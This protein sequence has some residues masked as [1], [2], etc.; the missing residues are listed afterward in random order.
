LRVLHINNIA[1]VANTIATAQRLLLGH[2]TELI[3]IIPHQ[4]L[5]QRFGKIQTLWKRVYLVLKARKLIRDRKPEV[6][7]LHFATS[8]IWLIGVKS[9]L[10]VHAHGS[11]IRIQKLDYIRRVI[12]YLGVR[13]AIA[14]IYATPD[15]EGYAKKYCKPLV[16]LPNP[17]DTEKYN[18]KLSGFRRPGQRRV[19]LFA[20]PSAIKGFDIAAAAL[21]MIL[22]K[23]PDLRVTVFK[24]PVSV[25]FF[26]KHPRPSVELIET[27]PQDYI[28]K[29]ICEHDIIIGQFKLGSFGVSEL[30]SMSCGKPVI[31]NAIYNSKTTDTTPHLQAENAEEI[32]QH[33]EFLMFA[34]VDSLTS[35]SEKSREYVKLNHSLKAIASRLD[36]LYCQGL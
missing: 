4:S 3:E 11:D 18:C 15:L 5:N 21:L 12:N 17:I 7:H 8:A 25:A 13:R 29:L 10:V 23:H 28:E 19:L 16:Y 6:V 27:V 33:L 26:E 2:E 35:I 9:K 32:V 22:A 14:I 36:G 34:T 1:D 20:V 24:N 30:Q 31:C